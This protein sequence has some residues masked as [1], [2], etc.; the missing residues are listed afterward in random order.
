MLANHARTQ[1]PTSRL[2]TRST[3]GPPGSPLSRATCRCVA[4]SEFARTHGAYASGSPFL[5]SSIL[6]PS[7]VPPAPPPCQA[8]S[9]LIWKQNPPNHKKHS[10]SC[11][12]FQISHNSVLDRLAEPRLPSRIRATES[13][14]PKDHP[15]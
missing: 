7:I 9:V 11:I 4:P 15:S 5:A 8:E 12:I 14:Y 10:R 2:E 3:A 6:P 13:A 1:E